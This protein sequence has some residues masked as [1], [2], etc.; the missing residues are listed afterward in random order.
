VNCIVLGCLS[1]LSLF[2]T[3]HGALRLSLEDT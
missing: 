1:R 2:H 3:I